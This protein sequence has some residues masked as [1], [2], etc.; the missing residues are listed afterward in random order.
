MITINGR[1]YPLWSQFVEGKEKFIGGILEDFGSSVDRAFGIQSASTTIKD[2]HLIPNGSN[3]AFFRVCGVDFNCGFDVKYGGITPVEPG[4][5]T[6]SGYGGHI[7]RIKEDCP[8][9]VTT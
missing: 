7:W 2:I 1:D 3:G 8:G 5:V 6:F 4:W 9:E